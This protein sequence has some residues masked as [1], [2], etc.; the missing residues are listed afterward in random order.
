MQV[1]TE[2]CTGVENSLTYYLIKQDKGIEAQE[3]PSSMKATRAPAHGRDDGC[4]A[5]VSSFAEMTRSMEAQCR[6]LARKV[7][8]AQVL[9]DGRQDMD[10][11][12]DK[13]NIACDRASATRKSSAA[14][15]VNE[16][17]LDDLRSLDSILSDLERRAAA[18]RAAIDAQRRDNVIL[19]QL[20]RQTRRQTAQIAT[21]CASLPQHL[22]FPAATA[23]PEDPPSRSA[24]PPVAA[25]AT[26]KGGNQKASRAPIS[27]P[28]TMPVLELVTVTELQEVPR[29]TRARLTIAQVNA[30]VSDIQKAMEKRYI[31]AT[32]ASVTHT[33]TTYYETTHFQRP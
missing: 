21:T 31:H 23:P 3:A 18:M 33:R 13:E 7:S 25:S 29:S 17:V 24:P 27:S 20:A 2:Y 14:A 11:I 6:S 9:D 22:P 30:A 28:P 32:G 16:H 12:T 1:Y 5:F 15:A 8:L 4:E 10:D 19:E 26:R